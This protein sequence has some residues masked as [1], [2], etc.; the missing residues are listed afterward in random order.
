MF[1]PV[2]LMGVALVFLLLVCKLTVATGTLS[3]LVFY[4]NIVGVN[5]TIFPP[6][7]STDALSVFTTNMLLTRIVLCKSCSNCNVFGVYSWCC[8]TPV[9]KAKGIFSKE[10]LCRLAISI[11]LA[12]ITCSLLS[13]AGSYTSGPTHRL[14]P[15]RILH[16]GSNHAC[17]GWH[18]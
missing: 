4:A 16:T 9:I 10:V 5:R 6:V 17:I 11:V 1:I 15:S 2:A 12:A 13:P 18:A 7:K 3:G 8:A 14:V